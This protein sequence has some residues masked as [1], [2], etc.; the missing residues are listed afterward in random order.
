M[1]GNEPL[2]GQSSA[3]K[4]PS[5]VFFW[6]FTG[7]AQRNPFAFYEIILQIG[8]KITETLKDGIEKNSAQG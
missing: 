2:G 8:K 1:S 4:K 3:H 6:H 5:E 7:G